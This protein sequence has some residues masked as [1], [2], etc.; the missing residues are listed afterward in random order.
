[1]PNNETVCRCVVP[2]CACQDIDSQCFGAPIGPL[3]A[4]CI[5]THRFFIANSCSCGESANFGIGKNRLLSLDPYLT[6]SPGGG[7]NVVLPP[8]NVLR[9]TFNGQTNV[10]EGEPNYTLVYVFEYNADGNMTVA[11]IKR[12]EDSGTWENLRRALF[13]YYG[14]SSGNSSSSSGGSAGEQ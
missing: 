11:T 8:C 10:Y 9:F 13:T 4:M 14:V 1:M 2:R 5:S 3:P 12:K 6:S 7:V